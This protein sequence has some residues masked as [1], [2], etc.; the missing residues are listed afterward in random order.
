VRRIVFLYVLLDVGLLL[1]VV[2]CS[3]ARHLQLPDTFC[4]NLFALQSS[5]QEVQKLRP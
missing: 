4:L 3:G 5:R 2:Q 1:F